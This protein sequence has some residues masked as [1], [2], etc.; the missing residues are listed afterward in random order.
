MESFEE[1]DWR[2]EKVKRKRKEE[3]WYEKIE[4]KDRERQRRKR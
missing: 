2:I 1:R 4:G 3:T